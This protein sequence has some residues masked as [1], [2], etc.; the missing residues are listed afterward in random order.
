VPCLPQCPAA[1]DSGCYPSVRHLL[2]VLGDSGC[3][4]SVLPLRAAP[5]HTFPS[6]PTPKPQTLNPILHPPLHTPHSP[7]QTGV[8]LVLKVTALPLLQAGCALA[9]QL[10]AGPTMTLVL[11]ALCP[12]VRW[13][14]GEGGFE[15]GAYER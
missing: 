7:S 12:T 3:Y 8:M 14:G 15:A 4:P 9:V 10:P 1:P 13:E 5:P 2:R 6:A 11:L